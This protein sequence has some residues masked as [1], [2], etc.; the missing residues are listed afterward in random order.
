VRYFGL[1]SWAALRLAAGFGRGR[2]LER[3]WLARSGM[4]GSGSVARPSWASRACRGIGV[5]A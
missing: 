3:G 1:R 4:V 5:D 2:G